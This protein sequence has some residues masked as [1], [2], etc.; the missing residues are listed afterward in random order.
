MCL[1]IG[2]L[3]NQHFPFG[4]DGKVLV[5]GVPILKH[6]KGILSQ[7]TGAAFILCSNSD[8]ITIPYN[9]TV[10]CT[11]NFIFIVVIVFTEPVPS[12][13]ADKPSSYE[14]DLQLLKE[15]DLNWEF[16]PC[17]GKC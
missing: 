9:N 8:D 12:T 4:T 10:T 7:C 16:G 2:T 6:F 11:Q 15:F 3:N 14:K 5:L 13:S 17:I 1:N